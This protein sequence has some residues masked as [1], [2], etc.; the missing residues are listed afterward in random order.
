MNSTRGSLHLFSS[1]DQVGSR[2][3]QSKLQETGTLFLQEKAIA[4]EGFSYPKR[5]TEGGTC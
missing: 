3:G 1:L 2:K 4:S 5:E